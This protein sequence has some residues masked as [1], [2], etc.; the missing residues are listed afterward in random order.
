MER[1]EIK[2]FQIPK[3]FGILR[4]NSHC[5]Y[6]RLNQTNRNSMIYKTFSDFRYGSKTASL[7]AATKFIDEN[8]DE[9]TLH[10]AE[11]SLYPYDLKPI[12]SL[13]GEEWKWVKGFEGKY[14]I[15]SHGRVKSFM[16]D[17]EQ[18][19]R[20]RFVCRNLQV[21]LSHENKKRVAGLVRDHF[22]DNPYNEH[23]I[24]FIDGNPANCRADNISYS[25]A[26]W[27]DKSLTILK[28]QATKSQD[29]RD[30]VD[31]RAGNQNAL[32]RI[33]KEQRG[34]LSKAVFYYIRL[35]RESY[36]FKVNFDAE[37]IIQETLLQA[38]LAIKG[39]LLR[40]V[41]FL[42]RWFK[43][44]ARNILISAGIKEVK[45]VPEFNHNKDGKEFNFIDYAIQN[46]LIADNYEATA[47]HST[48]AMR[49]SIE[50]KGGE[51][52]KI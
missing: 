30:I 46:D 12:P 43:I 34:Y 20:L 18:L 11:R 7:K 19:M 41:T 1:I 36:G 25:R 28:N 50:E 51:D 49:T 23:R 8:I 6:V 38:T 24:F 16:R 27:H 29:A 40:D 9:Q 42:R 32:N 47:I 48:L 3:K 17:K 35:Y 26:Y 21:N 14:Q 52:D 13:P 45:T 4:V 33:L 37:N 2:G 10:R 22:I 5:W 44:I 15:S 39:G 31:Y